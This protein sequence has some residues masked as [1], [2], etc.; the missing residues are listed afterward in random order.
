MEAVIHALA[1]VQ[2]PH[3]GRGTT[4]WQFCVILPGARIGASCNIC[5]HCFIENDV[6]VGDNAT[7]K[8]GV[9][10]WDGIRIDD[11]VF[12]GSNATFINNRHPRS[13][14]RPE[15]FERTWIRKGAS[16]GANATILSGL[17]IGENCIVGAG[18]VVTRSVPPNAVVVGNPARI[19]GYVDRVAP[20]QAFVGGIIG[21]A[22]SEATPVA[23]VTLHRF[24]EYADM[25]GS[26]TV[27]NFV[28]EVPFVPRRYFM[29]H[30]VPSS[31]TRGEHAHREC[32][33]FMVCVSGSCC[34][35]V[36]DGRSRS[37]VRLDSP[38]LGLN[39]PAG[40]WATQHN[41][42]RDAMLLVFASHPYD[43]ADYIR[44]YSEFLAEAE[45]RRQRAT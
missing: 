8:N 14:V 6:V 18:A 35:V 37:E 3:I 19:T 40:V 24:P 20:A 15:Q 12:I 21:A 4:V 44:D 13:K 16:I 10:L 2:S 26:V 17:T 27:G 31:E 45:E 22:S 29:V 1:D 38:C 33:Q 5:S 9:Q 39:V 23:G 36:D 34:V 25:R 41:Y 42:S 11:G 32:H 30:G 43:P 7:I 28:Q